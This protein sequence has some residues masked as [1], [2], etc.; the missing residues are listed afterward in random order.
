MGNLT[1]SKIGRMI[2]RPPCCSFKRV[3]SA[4]VLLR[5]CAIYPTPH[6]KLDKNHPLIY[7][8]WT[9]YPNKKLLTHHFCSKKKLTKTPAISIPH[10]T[11]A[12]YRFHH[13]GRVF[14]F[15]GP[16]FL[17][18]NTGTK[19]V[20]L[21]IFFWRL[22]IY[23]NSRKTKKKVKK[24]SRKNKVETVFTSFACCFVVL[25]VWLQNSKFHS[26]D[27]PDVPWF[28]L[29]KKIQME[30][31]RSHRKGFQEKEHQPK[32]MC[33]TGGCHCVSFFF[34]WGGGGYETRKPRMDV[35]FCSQG[36]F[37][38]VTKSRFL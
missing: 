10:S 13:E 7:S 5:T 4:D 21:T 2:G 1:L 3:D 16:T 6:R 23:I 18:R 26:Q 11:Q 14:F 15:C 35:L 34:F 29:S 32:H 38:Q 28:C 12:R 20:N 37:F 17:N 9:N 25:A 27:L 36:L 22:D 24:K 30:L 8:P 19:E 33:R 31:K